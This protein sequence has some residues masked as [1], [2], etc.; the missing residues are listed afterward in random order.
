MISSKRCYVCS[1]CERAKAMDADMKALEVRNCNDNE[2][3][4]DE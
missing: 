4:N 3:R 1:R 2:E